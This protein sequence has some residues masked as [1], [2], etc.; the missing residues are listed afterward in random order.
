MTEQ[1]RGA[2][3]LL[4]L[5]RCDRSNLAARGNN[6]CSLE[7]LGTSVFVE[8][9][10]KR[11]PNC[12]FGKDDLSFYCWIFSQSFRNTPYN[13]PVA[14]GKRSQRVLH[15]IP[16]QGQRNIRNIEWILRNKISTNPLRTN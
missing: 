16:E 5:S 8:H 7:H 11:L 13:L 12:E 3:D 10:D 6:F 1:D 2:Y 14:P 4:S 15:P 9:R